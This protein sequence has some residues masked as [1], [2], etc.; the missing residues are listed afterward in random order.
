M[1]AGEAVRMMSHLS[2]IL[3]LEEVLDQVRQLNIHPGT[4]SALVEYSDGICSLLTT[5]Q[6]LILHAYVG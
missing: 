1:T 6:S 3:H 4:A 5:P 2:M